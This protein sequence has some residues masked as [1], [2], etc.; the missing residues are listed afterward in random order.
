MSK[1]LVVEDSRTQAEELKILLEDAGHDVTIAGDAAQ[2]IAV[3]PAGHFEVVVSDIVMP[4]QSGYDLCRTLKASR[5]GRDVPFILLSSLNDPMDIIRGLECGA[6]NF[7][8]K[9]YDPDTLLARINAAVEN[10]KLR[11]ESKFKLGVEVYF[12]G[13]AFTITSD[14]EQILDLLMSTF[15]DIVRTNNQ[16][17]ASQSQLAEAKAQIEGHARHLEQ[18]VRQR[19]AAL[20]E[21][22]RSLENEIADRSRMAESLRESNA[23]LSAVISSSPLP[24]YVLDL[25]GNVSLWSATA[26]E[27]FGWSADEVLGKPPPFIEKQNLD[28]FLRDF[29]RAAAEHDFQ[30]NEIAGRT[31]DGKVIAL[32]ISGA[33]LVDKPGLPRSVV[34]VAAD[35]T[36]RKLIDRQL[37]HAQKME[38]V[39]QLTGGIAHDFNNLIGVVMGNLDMIADTF[40]QRTDVQ[41]MVDVAMEACRRGATLTRQLLAFSRRQ[42]LN[43]EL[44]DINATVSGMSKLLAT[45][46]GENIALNLVAPP[47]PCLVM[48]D[49]AQLES[50]IMNLAVNAAHAMSG[51][52]TLTV[53]TKA[54]ALDADYAAAHA[55]LKPG[56]YVLLQ[57]TDTG[58]GIPPEV[59]DRVFEPFFTTKP[60]GKGSGLG[61]S[62]VF[63]FVHQSGGNVKIY[64]EVGVGTTVRVYFPRVTNAGE[65]RAASTT[66]SDGMVERG[67]EAILLVEDNAGMRQTLTAQLRGLGYQVVEAAN[68]E[69]AL[70]ILTGGTRFD[71][72]FTDVVMPGSMSGIDLARAVAQRYPE[73][74]ILVSSGF[75][76]AAVAESMG[77]PAGA[78]FLNKPYRYRELAAKIR[79]VL[80][81]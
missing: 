55:E 68:A 80:E 30:G 26:E 41:S 81:K 74:K 15:E 4:G 65:P 16:L 47:E 22:N 3:F 10:R 11:N 5:A 73:L 59:L 48:T 17:R 60:E 1:I 13:Q 29:V 51:G 37:V 70:E 72:L 8:T 44:I 54:L 36:E 76:G 46:L 21:A 19:T 52:G 63:G 77:L 69:A 43:A 28:I 58:T 12:L 61:L 18:V 2:A 66:E 32:R 53:E 31:R 49:R 71:L 40:P 42:S 78:Q 7:L 23:L 27:T 56:E 14:K 34:H 38:A 33:S 75:P 67:N 57:I 79:E 50:A 62:Q 20:E 35:V 64:S 24:I 25:D 6:D 45:A 39:G 9:P